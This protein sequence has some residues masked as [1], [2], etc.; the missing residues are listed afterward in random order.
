[1]TARINKLIRQMDDIDPRLGDWVRDCS[2]DGQSYD[3]IMER[4]RAIGD[5]AEKLRNGGQ[6]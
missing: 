4:L 3:Q 1:M 5:A 2:R 6:A